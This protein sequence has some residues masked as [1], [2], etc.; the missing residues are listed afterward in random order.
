MPTTISGRLKNLLR[1]L[2]PLA[3]LDLLIQVP[4]LSAQAYAPK[5]HLVCNTGY[6]PQQCQAASAVLKRA[7]ARYPVDTLG[8]WTWVL[9]RTEDW[10]QIL[11]A[12]RVDTNVPAFSDLT[13]RVTFLD[14]S[15]VVERSVRSVELGMRWHMPIE[16]L[17]DLSIR[18]EL[19]HALCNEPKE[20]KADRV[21]I[22]LKDGTA[23]S[24]RGTLVAKSHPDETRPH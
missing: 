1:L 22:A 23:L 6:T 3:L 16:D 7:Q 14:G 18:H 13:K 24:C 19:A 12:M 4:T 15:L 20:S 2:A 8:K 21:A 5:Q 9:V 11:S 17:L 10:R